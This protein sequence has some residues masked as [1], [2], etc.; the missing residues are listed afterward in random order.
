MKNDIC[1]DPKEGLLYE[2]PWWLTFPPDLPFDDSEDI[3]IDL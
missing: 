2:T 3:D 1:S